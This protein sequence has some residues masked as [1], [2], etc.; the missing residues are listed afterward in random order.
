MATGPNRP[1]PG[2]SL[3]ASNDTLFRGREINDLRTLARPLSAEFGVRQ[4][5]FISCRFHIVA[6]ASRGPRGAPASGAEARRFRY[7]KAAADE[8]S[9]PHSK[10]RGARR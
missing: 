8:P 6:A 1:R 3:D 7:G 10:L 4:R 9:L 2:P 5:R